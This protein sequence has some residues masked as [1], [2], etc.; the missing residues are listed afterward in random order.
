MKPEEEKAKTEEAKQKKRTRTAQRRKVARELYDGSLGA[1]K[2]QATNNQN[3][4]SE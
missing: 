4:D 3:E 2:V 1:L